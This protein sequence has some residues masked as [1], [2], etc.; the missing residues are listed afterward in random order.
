MT[1]T[2]PAAPGTLPRFRLRRRGY[3]LAV[4]TH[5]LASVGWFGIAV[6]VAFC[7]VAAAASD[8]ARAHALYRAMELMPWLSVPAGILAVVTG[9]VLG[10]GTTY[11]LIRHWWVVAKIVIAVAVIVTDALLVIKA[12]HDAAV[13]GEPATPL[14]GSTIAHVVVLAL[15]TVLAVFKPRGRTPW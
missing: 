15:A 10:L 3:K 2:A 6:V 13:T 9:T 14:Y 1:A 5:V 4:T 8:A 11:G 7:G 12:A